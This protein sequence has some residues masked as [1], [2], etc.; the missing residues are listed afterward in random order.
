MER[1]LSLVLDDRG[2]VS[3]TLY[4]ADNVVMDEYTTKNFESSD[5]IR[6]KY[7][8]EI[9]EFLNKNQNY[10]N[11]IRNNS[12]RDFNGRIVLLQV[13]PNNITEFVEKKVLYKKHLIAFKQMC[14]D[15][16][17]MQEFS[18]LE[19]IGVNAYGLKK[20]VSPQIHREI[21]YDKTFNIKT[22]VNYIQRSL[23]NNKNNFYEILRIMIKAYKNQRAIRKNLP[24][25]DKIYKDY[26]ESKKVNISEN[27]NIQETCSFS[28][29]D[30]R[31]YFG[32]DGIS[33]LQEEQELFDLDDLKYIEDLDFLPDGLD[34]NGKSFK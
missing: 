3:L 15:K 2:L 14:K 18:R 30:E 24:T 28:V 8:K 21:S 12:K 10:L 6:K 1:K 29:E 20:L 17:T 23:K 33:Y 13:D 5:D 19:K 7:Q 22:R 32:V 9:D 4:R 25:I 27:H 31:K 26:L 34:R 11:A 16:G